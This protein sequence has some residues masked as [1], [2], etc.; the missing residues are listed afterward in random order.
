MSSDKK[1]DLVRVNFFDGQ[2]IT[3]K[4]LDTDQEYFRSLLSNITL[5]F[6]S[7]GIIDPNLNNE[8]IL[9]DFSKPGFYG[10]N[11]SKDIIDAGEYDGRSVN[12][13][14][15]PSDPV[16]GNRLE[17]LLKNS[18]SRGSRKTKMII[19]GRSFNSLNEN[20]DLVTEVLYLDDD[21]TKL[22]ANYFNRV[23]GIILNNYSGGT[24]KDYYQT[25]LESLNNLTKEASLVI[26]ESGPAK[27]F[28]YS[29]NSFQDL[30]P[31]Y[32][33]AYFISSSNSRTIQDEIALAIGSNG[34][35]DEAFI[36]LDGKDTLLLEKN[37]DISKKYGQKFI[38]KSNNLQ[39][40][41]IL[42]SVPNDSTDGYD[43]SGELVM[44]VY[45]LSTELDSC[46]SPRYPDQ[47]V[48]F[49]PEITPI[50]ELSLDQSDLAD[51]GIS[52]EE[53]PSIVPFDFSDTLLANPNID[54]S[55]SKDKYFAFT[56]S[57]VGSNLKGSVRVHRGTYNSL[58]KQELNIPLNPLEKYGRQN[59]VFTQ[60]DPSTKRYV[61]DK[62]SILWYR[63]RS[64]SA[65]VTDGACYTGEGLIVVIPKYEDYVGSTKLLRFERHID[66]VDI[67]GARNYLV[68]DA[69]QK[70]LDADVHP[71][72]GNFIYTR[73]QDVPSLRFIKRDELNSY[74]TKDLPVILG[75]I[76]DFNSRSAQDIEGV[77]S[78][79]GSYDTNYFY[80]FDPSDEIKTSQLIGRN[81]IP[82]TDCQC[83]NV[84]K[85]VE[86]ECMSV[87]SGDL[88][89]DGVLNNLDLQEILKITGNTINSFETERRLFGES[90][91]LVEFKQADLNNDQTI[92]GFDVQLLEDAITGLKNFDVPDNLVFYKVYFE[93]LKDQGY[94]IVFADATQ[95]SNATS[96]SDK[97]DFTS[98][99]QEIA[100]AIRIGDKVTIPTGF[101][102]EGEYIIYGK[103]I[104]SD[105]L[106]VTISV[107][108]DFGTDISFLG[109]SNFDITVR[110]KTKT[111]IFTDNFDL[112]KVPFAS[113]NYKI[114]LSVPNFKERFLKVCDLRRYVEFSYVDNKKNSCICIETACPEEECLPDTQNEKYLPG[115]LLLSGNLLDEE[116]K[117][118]RG[119]YEYAT[120]TI[121]L[122]PGSIENCSINIYDNF[123]KAK[124][125]SCETIAGFPAMKYSDGTYIGCED[126]GDDTDLT[127]GKVKLSHAIASLYVDGLIDGYSASGG[128]PDLQINV[129]ASE[130]FEEKFIDFSYTGFNSWN[131][132]GSSSSNVSITTIAGPNE[133][134]LFELTTVSATGNRFGE[135]EKPFS[136]SDMD[137]D[138][139]FDFQLARSSW[140]DSS[141]TT[142]KVS[143]Y[144]KFV[145]T[146]TDGSSSIL[147]VGYK[148][149]GGGKTKIIYSGQ[150]FDSS[151]NL[152][153]EFD[154]E[155][156]RIE[157][158]TETM[159]FRV[160]RIGDVVTAYFFNP[161]VNLCD[162]GACDEYIRIGQN[163]Q[164]HAGEGT[165]D[166]SFVI[167]QDNAPNAS[168]V[169]S[170]K[171][172]KVE[173]RSEYI[174]ANADSVITLAR[175][176]SSNQIDRTMFN[177][178]LV[179]SSRTNI[180]SASMTLKY[181]SSG[182]INE[183][184]NIIPLN[185]LDADNLSTITNL[186][187]TINQSYIL[188]FIPGTFTSGQEVSI[189]ISSIIV[190]YLGQTGHISGQYK[191]L[192]LEPDGTSNMSFD[193]D[194]KIEISLVYEEIS[195]GV[196][197]KVGLDL[198]TKTGIL[199]LK[200]KN[201]L[202]DKL[203][204]ENRTV[205]KVGVH[206]KKAGFINEDIE[207]DISLLKNI[208]VGDCLPS[209]EYPS[210]EECFFVTGS[211]KTG[212]YIQGPFPCV[213]K[214]GE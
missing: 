100:L 89:N 58:K 61:D 177:F 93:E 142:G 53:N 186:A 63:V 60:F 57:R 70:F 123:I 168:E 154:F 81:F 149:I 42:M 65:E 189:D 114:Y 209:E 188:D 178:P 113:K 83:S 95:T 112:I 44:S 185:V 164:F 62:D 102:D 172:I 196:V 82:D 176:S 155:D 156:A 206:M 64:S 128:L 184:V 207:V 137:D 40:I 193:I 10:D 2:R 117:T 130:K 15:Q 125:N 147:K 22:T 195:T 197:F 86:S 16:Y 91:S 191:A 121:P 49:D 23:Y 78:E 133:P 126:S 28:P 146:N 48:D 107:T 104:A 46:G 169:F 159:L 175:D 151:S 80:L 4:D 69:K 213:L 143:F 131:I 205:V 158:V 77:F 18:N 136:S 27:L 204:R 47:P 1:S 85:I 72:T 31:N 139:V 192:I 54:P 36:D 119:D 38:S 110:S 66:L 170:G 190:T 20:N 56:V 25:S 111:N 108:D 92:D 103:E 14:V 150:N 43:W 98:T 8:K 84:Y 21:E 182:T 163:T 71:R 101:P 144:A 17:V 160:R 106:S 174:S 120:V 88:N 165:V 183:R 68:L 39:K 201:I 141:L 122:P 94:P 187:E 74:E 13:D 12:V 116:G 173:A 34:S 138:F 167:D 33:L 181:A 32:D 11:S 129:L 166:Y 67:S 55:L 132:N 157:T 214:V 124:D 198:D 162:Q 140:D 135:L 50:A 199:S 41:E 145:V 76:Y 3:E 203:I 105:G 5:D 26:K 99:S 35:I 29:L 152:V 180:I 109:S 45:E 211:V 6:H 148:L 9:V 179:L 134:A 210:E 212:T 115:N 200:T 79:A 37:G 118:H 153:Y 51:M 73:I 75:S 127:K 52:L 97:I 90:L 96:G 30:S 194:S 87:K 202:Y 59:Q 19:V 161:Q 24:G 7:S 208:G 171:V